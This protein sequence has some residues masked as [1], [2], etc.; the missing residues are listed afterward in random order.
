MSEDE[1]DINWTKQVLNAESEVIT[2][3]SALAFTIFEMDGQL[4]LEKCI[5]ASA[6]KRQLPAEQI[7]ALKY[8]VIRR[9]RMLKHLTGLRNR[10]VIATEY[11]PVESKTN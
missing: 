9:E 11:Q 7:L 2:D 6:K 4:A 10:L 8:L 1:D 5:L 3:A